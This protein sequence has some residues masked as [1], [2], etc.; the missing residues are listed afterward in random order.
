M[1]ES[2]NNVYGVAY[3]TTQCLILALAIALPLRYLLRTK[4]FV[5]AWLAM[6]LALF[7]WSLLLCLAL[8][9][10]IWAVSGDGRAAFTFSPDMRGIPAIAL[11]GWMP[12]LVFCTAAYLI[13]VA[14]L[15][16]R[17]RHASNSKA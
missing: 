6:W 9:L 13:H 3:F 10:L 17:S 11:T 1:V 16:F 5:R 2:L 4:R 12:S 15:Y 7:L 14:W 8:L